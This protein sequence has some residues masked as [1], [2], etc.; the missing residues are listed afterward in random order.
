MADYDAV[1]IGA[2]LSGLCSGA[3]LTH[4]GLKVL[5]LEKRSYVG[6]RAASIKHGKHILDDGPHMPDES[7]DLEK[8]FKTL[9]L[10]YPEL[11]PYPMGDGWINGEWISMREAF[12]LQEA[13]EVLQEFAAISD[14]ALNDYND[15]SV[16]DWC[17]TRKNTEEWST[18]FRYFAQ[19]LLVGNKFEDLSMGELIFLLRI[20]LLQGKR[21]SQVGG[22]VSGGLASLTE[23]L[24]DIIENNGG[25]IRLSC[26]V[27]DIVIDDGKVRGV[28][29]ETG[30]P[31][32][33]SQ[34]LETEVIEA[35]VVI[36]TLPIWDLFK[37]VSED[38]FPGWYQDWIRDSGKRVSHIWSLIYAV[39]EPLWDI[40]TFRWVPRLPRTGTFGI[41]FQ[42]QTYG[43][44]ADETQVNVVIQGNYRDLPD[45]NQWQCAK[46]RR[47]V[48]RILKC[49]EEDA[50]E[51]IPGLVEATKW[52]IG[53]A[54][55][56]GLT[57]APGNTA[58]HRPSMRVPAVE[59]LYLLSD[60]IREARGLGMQSIAK[61]SL[62]L[63]ELLSPMKNV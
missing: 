44:D 8:L 45:L 50:V 20:P 35:P 61:A 21:L 2:G 34:V 9:G 51:L 39:E 38:E 56:F 55:V 3:L 58:F 29:I 14:E 15:I 57:E 52:R 42:H 11:L 59:N 18:M 23:P 13:R 48:R 7:G 10:E 16:A 40:R 19:L 60:S 17:K 47:E 27:N 36:C 53:Q 24:R 63:G 25:E 6:G 32:F 46:T 62:K 33:P 12:P 43:D 1:I 22:T 41:F 31:L 30:D 49:L 5:L 28:E 54:S 26:P 37:V 4:H